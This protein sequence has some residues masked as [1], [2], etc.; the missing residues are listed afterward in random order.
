MR[1]VGL[2]VPSL[3]LLLSANHDHDHDHHEQ[4]HTHLHRHDDGHHDHAHVT[5]TGLSNNKLAMWLFL[6]SEVMFFTG[7][8]GAYIVLRFGQETWADPTAATPPPRWASSWTCA[9]RARCSTG[10]SV[11]LLACVSSFVE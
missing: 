2:L 6:G 7:L 8:I 4:T 11:G 5:S 9:P 1:A 10:L 3:Y